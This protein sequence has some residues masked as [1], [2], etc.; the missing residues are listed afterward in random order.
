MHG[1][2]EK[3][4]RDKTVRN[5]PVS[6]SLTCCISTVRTGVDG[7]AEVDMFGQNSGVREQKQSFIWSGA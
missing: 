1:C 3:G 2:A 5:W 7:V 4:K 6:T